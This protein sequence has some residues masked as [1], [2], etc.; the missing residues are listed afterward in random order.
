MSSAALRASSGLPLLMAWMGMPPSGRA[1]P[2]VGLGLGLGHAAHPLGAVQG[3]IDAVPSPAGLELVD[4]AA[5]KGLERLGRD[6]ARAGAGLRPER[7][8]DADQLDT[9]VLARDL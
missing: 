2:P 9:L 7:R 8:F 4:H 6:P 1:H 5:E 3:Q